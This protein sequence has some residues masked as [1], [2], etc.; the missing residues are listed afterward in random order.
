MNRHIFRFLAIGVTALLSGA[1]ND[2]E[3]DLLEPKV[4]FEN[5]ENAF[6]IEDGHQTMT[7]DVSSR[8][9]A[10][11]SSQ[12]DVSYSIADQSVVDEYNTKNG[13][14]YEM[15][16][17]SH[18]KLSSTTSVIP[19]GKLYANKVTMELSG[20]E[21]MEEGKS[22]ILPIRVHSTSVSA[23][24]DTG[25]TYYILSKPIKI[26]EVGTFTSHYISVKFPPGTYFTS[27]TYETLIYVNRFSSNNTIMGTEGVM[28]FRIGDVTG[29]T[30]KDFLEAAGR[31]KYNVM[32]G[33]K[34]NRWYHVALTYDQPS[35]KTA[36]YVNGSKWAESAWAIPGFDP[37]S[38]VG[39]NIGK[40][41]GFPWGERPLNGYLSETRVWSVARTENQLKQNMLSVDPKSEGLALYYKLNGSEKQEGG[42]ITDAASGLNGATNG[43][44]ITTLDAPIVIE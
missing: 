15:F 38:D 27:F 39:F 4:Y 12:V 29:G 19:N 43:I 31:Q 34:P 14:S 10:M 32:E 13:T 25:I 22:L 23:L 8:L 40:L 11:V 24:P 26:T 3:S 33:L 2:S 9:S 18:V 30:P 20:L 7:F 42:V 6:A 36:I 37:N 17:P 44:R 1:C 16:D 28:I 5:K 41:K 35:G 21:T